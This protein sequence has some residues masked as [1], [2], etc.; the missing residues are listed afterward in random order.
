MSIPV[1]CPRVL[2]KAKKTTIDTLLREDTD[3]HSLIRRDY[4]H[5]V[6]PQARFIL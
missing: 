2:Q 5:C 3:N 4:E 1:F 6:E